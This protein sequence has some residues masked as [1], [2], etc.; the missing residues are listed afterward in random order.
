VAK[1]I[2]LE[3]LKYAFLSRSIVF[4]SAALIVTLICYLMLNVGLAFIMLIFPLL[5][6]IGAISINL[7]VILFLRSK[8]ALPLYMLIASPSV[9]LS[10]G[11]G[12]LSRL[13]IGNLL[14]ALVVLIW[15][16]QVLLP[17]RK[18]GRVLLEGSLLIP[19]LFLI[20]V[21]LLSIIY[22]RLFPD[23]NIPYQYPHSHV[24]ITL[25]NISEITILIGLPMFLV[26]VPGLV[27]T[28]RDAYMVML[29]FVGVGML[30]ALGTIFATPLGL[31]SREVILGVRRPEVFGVDSSA[32]GSLL[33]LFG[34]LAI[35]QTLYATCW[36]SRLLWGA[37]SLLLCLGVIMSFGRESWIGLFLAVFV[38]VGF[39]TRNWLVLL[40]LFAP[41]V[42]LLIP[43]ASD[44]FDPSKTY[45]SDRLKIWQDAIAI[46][47]KSPYMGIGAGNFQ[48]FDRVYGSDKVGVAHNQYLQM[49][50]ETGVQ[51]LLCLIWLLVAIGIKALQLFKAAKSRL[52]KSIALAYIGYYVSILFGGFFTGIFIPSAAAGGGT[53]PFVAASCRWMLLGLV[54]S[55]PIW[56]TRCAEEEGER[57]QAEAHLLSS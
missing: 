34:S 15:I 20:V 23:P 11:S 2:S 56:D 41:L 36:K 43:G 10:S 5:G 19:L 14:F 37:L 44:F 54:L 32:L 6:L 4:P 46:W 13:Y 42:L 12:I 17:E 8:L 25:V 40:V 24:S 33:L 7:V 16:F 57:E 45:G 26:I 55:I 18:S 50:A 27:R 38:M 52:G 48:F 39:R 22:S 47:L 53:G 28:P 51:G 30:Y 35:T 3:Q 21:G 49:L 9:A 29:S 31:Y 1:G